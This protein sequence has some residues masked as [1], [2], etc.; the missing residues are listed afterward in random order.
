[1]GI[2]TEVEA[3]ATGDGEGAVFWG[4]TSLAPDKRVLEEDEEGSGIEADTPS[5]AWFCCEGAEA[6]PVAIVGRGSF[7][8]TKGSKFCWIAPEHPDDGIGGR[9][10]EGD[11][12]AEGGIEE[13]TLSL[14]ELESLKSSSRREFSML[15]SSF[16]TSFSTP[17]ASP[18]PSELKFH[19][20]PLML[21][22]RLR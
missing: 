5:K 17:T 18:S 20:S 2:E 19:E 14:Q 1:M 3:C 7:E 15:E 16:I 11:S 8:V 22:P 10:M 9:C 6:D 4:P 21:L 12:G 13:S